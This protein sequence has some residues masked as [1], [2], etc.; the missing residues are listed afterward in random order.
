MGE[1]GNEG[2]AH[3]KGAVGR[4]QSAGFGQDGERGADGVVK[5]WSTPPSS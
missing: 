3:G 1:K 2:K 5:V 4:V